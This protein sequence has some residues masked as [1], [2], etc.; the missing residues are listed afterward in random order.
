LENIDGYAGLHLFSVSMMAGGTLGVS[1]AA[2]EFILVIIIGIDS[3]EKSLYSLNRKDNFKE[4]V[5]CLN[6]YTT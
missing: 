5:Q 1:L 2:K 3:L 4:K 6:K